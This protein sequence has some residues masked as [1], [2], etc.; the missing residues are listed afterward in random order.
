M[1]I[2]LVTGSEDS[3]PRALAERLEEQEGVHTGLLRVG[4]L[5]TYADPPWDVLVDLGTPA[6]PYLQA[7]LRH[8]ACRGVRVVNDPFVVEALDRFTALTL[9]RELGL[10]A[11]RA[12]LLPNKDFDG[13]GPAALR[14]LEHPLDWSG[15]LAAVGGRGLLVP[16]RPGSPQEPRTVTTPGELVQAYDRTGTELMLLRESPPWDRYVRCLVVG[17]SVIVAPYEPGFSR[18]LLEPSLLEESEEAAC[19]DAALRISR[20]CG[21]ALTAVELALVDGQVVVVDALDPPPDLGRTNLTAF[22]FERVVSETAALCL[23]L[24][25]LGRR[26]PGEARPAGIRRVEASLSGRA[27]AA[28]VRARDAG[29]EAPGSG[30]VHRARREA[31]QERVSRSRQ[32]GAPDSDRGTS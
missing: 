17:E 20:A 7:V 21:L 10:S 30:G 19:V 31:A 27:D 8:A 4:A 15:A 16:A 22:Y 25:R 26:P 32:G 9:T 6:L 5:G 12:V 11:A 14:C 13:A 3:F 1:R 2:G 29:P 24:A 28:A 23:E 18:Y